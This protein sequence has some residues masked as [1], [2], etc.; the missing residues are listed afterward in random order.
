MGLMARVCSSIR[1]SQRSKPCQAVFSPSN[2]AETFF[3]TCTGGSAAKVEPT[4]QN[5][6]SASDVQVMS[7]VPAL[8]RELSPS[9]TGFFQILMFALQELLKSYRQWV[10]AGEKKCRTVW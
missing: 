8:I 1:K 9:P 4:K 5:A 6:H 10:C 7:L 3:T 2:V